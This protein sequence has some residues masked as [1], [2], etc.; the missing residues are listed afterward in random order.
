MDIDIFFGL[1][2]LYLVSKLAKYLSN[3]HV[4][5]LTSLVTIVL[6]LFARSRDIWKTATSRQS[7]RLGEQEIFIALA[8]LL[9]KVFAERMQ[10][11]HILALFIHRHPRIKT[12]VMNQRYICGITRNPTFYST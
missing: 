11:L 10:D 9:S 2:T 8:A 4:P 5:P 7:W 3:V 6:R 12:G 1:Y